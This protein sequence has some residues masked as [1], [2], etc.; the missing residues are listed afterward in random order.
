MTRTQLVRDRPRAEIRRPRQRHDA[1]RR[2]PLRVL[3][4]FR[5]APPAA[6]ILFSD[7][8]TTEGL[9]LADAAQEARRKGV[10]IFAIGLGRD[11]PPRDIEIADVLVDDVVFVNDSSAFKSQIKASGLEGQSAKITLRREG[12]GRPAGR[13]S[14][15]AACRPA[16][17]DRAARRPAD[18]RRATLRMLSKSRCATTKP[19]S[20][21]TARTRMSPSATTKSAC[22]SFK[23]TPATSFA[24]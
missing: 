20:K 9:P 13:A 11:A 12:V 1:T 8:V 5:G 6:I 22:C 19:T 14:D 16:N 2:R 18:E 24:F 17:T 23:D 21:T 10:P 15:H 7:G 3:D 4:D